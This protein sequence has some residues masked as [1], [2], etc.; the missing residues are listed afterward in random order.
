MHVAQ[1]W[2]FD[3]IA[4]EGTQTLT[5]LMNQSFQVVSLPPQIFL[6]LLLQTLILP[7]IHFHQEMY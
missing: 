2:V 6:M 7:I 1:P 4:D 5:L 3:K